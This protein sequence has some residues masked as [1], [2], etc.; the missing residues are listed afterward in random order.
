MSL[1]A[2]LRAIT[3]ASAA[4]PAAPSDSMWGRAPHRALPD[5]AGAEL[6]KKELRRTATHHTTNLAD[7][8]ARAYILLGLLGE[9]GE[10]VTEALRPD[11]DR[12]KIISEA[13][14]V[15]WSLDA[16]LAQH[17]ADLSDAVAALEHKMLTRPTTSPR[18]AAAGYRPAPT[19]IEALLRE[20]GW[21]PYHKGAQHDL[22]D[23]A[24]LTVEGRIVAILD[25][26]DND[27]TRAEHPTVAAAIGAA[28]DI[29]A[30]LDPR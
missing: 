20:P 11:P 3:T 25:S 28:L 18:M 4:M 21:I 8:E 10:L 2:T 30:A 14:D 17:G 15:L 5:L 22:P 26:Q 27:V 9:I 12:A 23:G 29:V 16:L 1:S 13:G 19:T 7:P 6:L 24:N